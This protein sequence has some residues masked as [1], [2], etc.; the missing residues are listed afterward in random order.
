MPLKQIFLTASFKNDRCHVNPL[1]KQAIFSTEGNEENQEYCP[2][3]TQ[4]GTN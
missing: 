2:R 3:I 4:I 1:A